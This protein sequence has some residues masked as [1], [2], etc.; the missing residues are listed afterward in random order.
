L[1]RVE[2]RL[3]RVLLGPHAGEAAGAELLHL[4]DLARWLAR[5]AL[6]PAPGPRLASAIKV[7]T[8]LATT[9]TNAA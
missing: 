1:H 2:D 3:A 5:H 9:R 8:V 6:Q 4:P 7:S